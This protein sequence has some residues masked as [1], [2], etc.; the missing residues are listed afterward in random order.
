MKGQRGIVDV[1]SNPGKGTT[2]TLYFPSTEKKVVEEKP[3][4]T[5]ALKGSETILVVD[6]EQSVLEVSKKILMS[7]GYTVYGARSGQE[8]IAFFREKKA[9]IDLVLLD[10]IM[11]AL[12]G[13]ETFDRLR[14]IDPSVKVL[15]CSGYS[16]DGQAQQI[17]DKGCQGFVQKP[18]TIAVI[19]RKLREVLERPAPDGAS[20]SLIIE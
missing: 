7:L 20:D 11:P 4:I 12:S 18:F 9:S 3:A 15:L 6:D 2:F 5:K 13:S 1:R 17:I 10:M 19:S 14:Q 16:L 8:A